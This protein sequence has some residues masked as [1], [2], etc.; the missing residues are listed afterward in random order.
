MTGFDSVHN[1]SSSCID[2][3]YAVVVERKFDLQKGV[4][5]F[6]HSDKL[7]EFP[8]REEGRSPYEVLI[9]EVALKRT[10]ATATS[11]VYFE[12]LEKFPTI[13]SLDNATREE[14]SIVFTPLGL[15]NQKAKALKD[16][17]KYLIYEEGGK[18]PCNLDR[19]LKIPGI[20]AYSAR[21]VLSFAFDIPA[22]VVDSNVERIIHK[23]FYLSI[24]QRLSKNNYQH[25]ADKIL[26]S[27]F[28]REYNFALLDIG[29]L[30]CKPVSPLCPSCTLS[31]MCDYKSEFC[32]GNQEC[33]FPKLEGTP[34]LVK[35]NRKIRRL[36]QSSL[37]KQ[38][39]ISKHTLIN[40]EKG[41]TN[42]NRTT[43]EKVA[44]ALNIPIEELI[45]K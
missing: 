11:K 42:P 8:W 34:E 45:I 33:S 43:L 31:A 1:S 23:L 40:I 28:H 7:R 38:A 32:I 26:P 24:P 27:E 41:R 35:R 12:I 9:A 25:F 13:I 22:A 2:E 4:L 21:A 17:S 36:N 19:L 37:A 15:Q 14:I 30:V 29:A 18:V 39:G 6:V 3:L 10:T 5:D 16:L 20:G 44:T